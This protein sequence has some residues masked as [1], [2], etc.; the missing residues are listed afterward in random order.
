MLAGRLTTTI[1]SHLVM[2]EKLK[3]L[4]L[5]DAL[6][7]AGKMGSQV[8]MYIA[9]SPKKSS[10]RLYT[11]WFDEGITS[12]RK[13]GRLASILSKYHLKDWLE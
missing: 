7:P 4:G 6:I 1:E 3:E 13:S 8:P 12:L 9:C 5:Q 2:P 10:S 11:K